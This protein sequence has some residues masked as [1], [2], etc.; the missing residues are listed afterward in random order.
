[1]IAEVT[2]MIEGSQRKISQ[3]RILIARLAALH[4]EG[5]HWHAER[6]EAAEYLA[7]LIR[8]CQPGHARPCEPSDL[9]AM[10]RIIGRRC[11]GDGGAFG[12]MAC[13]A[14]PYLSVWR[15]LVFTYCPKTEAAAIYRRDLASEEARRAVKG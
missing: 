6:Y 5:L 2:T 9:A 10:V 4:A 13:L 14:D 15:D 8:R 7:V 3:A 1:M 11:E 12:F